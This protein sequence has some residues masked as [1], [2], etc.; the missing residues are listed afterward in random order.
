MSSPYS[1]IRERQIDEVE[2]T[3]STYRKNGVTLPG[4]YYGE[5]TTDSKPEKPDPNE[6]ARALHP[7]NRRR[8]ERQE[9]GQ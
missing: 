8:A 5:G 6:G 3:P 2:A 1:R 7:A 4:R 9:R